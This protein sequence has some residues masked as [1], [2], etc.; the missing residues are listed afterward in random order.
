[1]AWVLTNLSTLLNMVGIL[2]DI[3]GA[4]FVASEVIRQYRGKR[5]QEDMAFAFDD[6]VI[7]QPPK[8][9]KQF[10]VWE[11]LKYRNMKWGLVLL[12]VGFLLQFL[13]N[14]LQL[15]GAS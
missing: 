12:T 7:Q 6:L 14:V 1:M 9:T 3:V 8:E 15:K 2:F 4:F 5:Y 11:R 13:A 10:S